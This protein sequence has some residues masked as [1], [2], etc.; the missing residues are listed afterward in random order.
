[1][2]HDIINNI[3]DMLNNS[4]RVDEVIVGNHY[5]RIEHGLPVNF[6]YEPKIRPKLLD[7]LLITVYIP[8]TFLVTPKTRVV[9]EHAQ[10]GT[11]HISFDSTYALEITTTNISDDYLEK[12]NVIALRKLLKQ[13][14]Q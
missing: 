1:M 11:K 8:R 10:H 5:I 2:I 13:M 3:R 12:V 9:I 7:P 14:E 4:E 6:V